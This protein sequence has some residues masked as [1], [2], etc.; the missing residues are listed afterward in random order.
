M[1]EAARNIEPFDEAYDKADWS[2]YE[3]LPLFNAANRINAYN[4]F[5]L[6]EHTVK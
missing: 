6:M 2:R 1:T 4:T 5:L 3:H